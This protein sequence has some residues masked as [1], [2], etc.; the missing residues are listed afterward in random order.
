MAIAACSA[1][2]TQGIEG[3][4]KPNS[5]RDAV[6]LEDFEDTLGRWGVA[7]ALS[8]LERKHTLLASG[9]QAALPISSYCSAA[10]EWA[11]TSGPFACARLADEAPTC[12]AR[13]LTRSVWHEQ[14]GQPMARVP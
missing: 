1:H 11:V 7:R 14:T 2:T 12:K 3:R 9:R 5:Q 13:S 8:E 10:A 6:P 4:R